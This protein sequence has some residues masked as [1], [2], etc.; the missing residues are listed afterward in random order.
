MAI[1]I[2]KEPEKEAIDLKTVYEHIREEEFEE[3]T[4]EHALLTSY[5]ASARAY[6]ED[7]TGRSFAP[8]TYKLSMDSF[9]GRTIKLPY[10]PLIDVEYFK[11]VDRDGDSHEV[12]K[13][14]YI[15]DKDS[16]P[17]RI[18]L[19]GGYSWPTGL[20]EINGVQITFESGYK[21]LPDPLHQAVLM[22]IGHMYE[23]RQPVIVGTSIENL[24]FSVKALSWPYRI[25]GADT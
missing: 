21:Q 5:V 18:Y 1:V 8:K 25:W 19:K 10:S 11:Y 24:P 15:L 20:Q 16:T 6:L 17:S 13:D 14:S 3:S 7:F 12:E 23:E 22:L 4:P 2:L 9:P